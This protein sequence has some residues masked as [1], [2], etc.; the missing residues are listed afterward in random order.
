MSCS[1]VS[2]RRE[3]CS[4]PRC[5]WAPNKFDYQV[6]NVNFAGPN[7]CGGWGKTGGCGCGCRD[8]GRDGGRDGFRDGG[9]DGF[10]DGGRD[11]FRDGGRDGRRDGFDNNYRGFGVRSAFRYGRFGGCG[12]VIAAERLWRNTRLERYYSNLDPLRGRIFA[13]GFDQPDLP[14]WD[15]DQ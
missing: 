13:D 15:G 7:H 5:N 2:E 9:R 6:S 4:Y 14:N 1:C 11:G 12:S 8:G 10:R 3:F